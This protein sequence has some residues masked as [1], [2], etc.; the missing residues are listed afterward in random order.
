[1]PM[2]SLSQIADAF[3]VLMNTPLVPSEDAK[4]SAGRDVPLTDMPVGTR[5]SRERRRRSNDSSIST[6]SSFS[7]SRFAPV[8]PSSFANPLVSDG[9]FEDDGD[10]GSRSFGHENASFS[11]QTSVHDMTSKSL[12]PLPPSLSP[13]GLGSGS[14]RG[15]RVH[16]A[17]TSDSL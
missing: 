3:M 17:D 5:F 7:T 1:M 15:S 8:I 2:L 9:M 16:F 14:H 13:S 11:S 4:G 6:D 12:P 10:S